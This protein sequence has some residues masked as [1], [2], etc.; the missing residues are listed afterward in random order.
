MKISNEVSKRTVTKEVIVYHIRSG[1]FLQDKMS[2][3]AGHSHVIE[4]RECLIYGF[5]F[6][7]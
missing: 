3:D 4:Q 1:K 5:Y 2:T 6:H 7:G